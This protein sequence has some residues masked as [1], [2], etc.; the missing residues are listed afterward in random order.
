MRACVLACARYETRQ[1]AVG[2]D[3][4]WKN[5]RTRGPLSTSRTSLQ[6]LHPIKRTPARNNRRRPFSQQQWFRDAKSTLGIYTQ[7][8]DNYYE[9]RVDNYQ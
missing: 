5:E 6:S 2:L 8:E 4:I 7:Q 3:K 1:E 9:L